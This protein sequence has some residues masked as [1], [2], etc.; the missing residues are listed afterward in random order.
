MIALIETPLISTVLAVVMMAGLLTEWKIYSDWKPETS[1]I[2][3][4]RT[5]IIAS[6]FA[7]VAFAIPTPLIAFH[8]SISSSFLAAGYCSA[9]LIIQTTGYSKHRGLTK[10]ATFP[11]GVGLAVA[12]I[13]IS[14]RYF[15]TGDWQV[16]TLIL[17]TAP[18]YCAMIWHLSQELS[19]RDISLKLALSKALQQTELAQRH[20]AYAEAQRL[21]ALRKGEEAERLRQEAVLHLERAE[22]A[23]VAK[24][25]F[26]AS[27]SH[28]IRTPMNGILGLADM[29]SASHGDLTVQKCSG[30]IK[31]SAENLMVIINDI[32]DFSK[33]EAVQVELD[34]QPFSLADLLESVR[35]LSDIQ[36]RA[37][38]VEL[39]V[40][41]CPDVCGQLYGDENRI[42]QILLNLVGNAIKFTAEG[43]IELRVESFT[44]VS[45]ASIA[46]LRFLVSDTGIGI[47]PDRLETMFEKFT[48]ASTGTTREYGGTGLGLAISSELAALL[49]G[50][51]RAVS[52]EG[53]GST[54]YFDISLPLVRENGGDLAGTNIGT[55]VAVFV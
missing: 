52:Q 33:L 9:A 45:T 36:L 1:G 29:L 20:H 44:E 49:G 14:I 19:M 30:I 46:K 32:L 24:S 47:P 55:S 5:L 42:R 17:M 28:E 51:L 21:D 43:R 16:G 6:G 26:L 15:S 39:T 25:D 35:V 54:F 37:E 41:K 48:Q 53:V 8:P 23:H 40:T 2:A 27:M 3:T 38:T 31:T 18:L 34:P 4:R 7:A 10:A 50:Q 13:I 22:A 11:H 12:A